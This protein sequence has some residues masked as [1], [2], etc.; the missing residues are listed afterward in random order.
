MDEVH[1]LAFKFAPA[2]IKIRAVFIDPYSPD[3]DL[4]RDFVVGYSMVRQ[5]ERATLAMLMT[6]VAFI[7]KGEKST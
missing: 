6:E 7:N 2:Y 1:A 4:F 3:A 5:N